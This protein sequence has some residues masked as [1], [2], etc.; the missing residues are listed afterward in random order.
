M[1]KKAGQAMRL[2]SATFMKQLMLLLA[3]PLLTFPKSVRENSRS[4]SNFSRISFD[5]MV[6]CLFS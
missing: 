5:E 1:L 2:C 4:S 3:I 6:V